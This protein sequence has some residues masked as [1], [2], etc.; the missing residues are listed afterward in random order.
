MVPRG[1]LSGTLLFSALIVGWA[2]SVPLPR[3]GD[4]RGDERV[5]VGAPPPPPKVEIVPPAPGQSSAEVWLSGEWSWRDDRWEWSPG[6]WVTP[7]KGATYAPPVV[8]FLDDKQIAWIPGT[9]H[10]WEGRRD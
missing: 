7:P 5:L 2:A 10:G 9:W 8:I 1:R 3:E 6:R 4:H